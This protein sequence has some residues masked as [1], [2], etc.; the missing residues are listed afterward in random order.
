M[1]S[2][3][4]LVVIG[5]GQAGAELAVQAR[6]GGWAGGI[7][8][9][10]D[11][12]QLP[13]HRPPLSKSGLTDAS[14]AD[15][16][17][18]KARTTY[19]KAGIELM[20]GRL[21][22]HVDLALATVHFVDGTSMP[23]TRL[24]FTTG[25]RARR[26]P[27][28]D[29]L[30]QRI[31]NVHTLRS[32]ADAQRLRAGLVPGQRLVVI[33][34]GFVGLEVAAIAAAKGLHVVLLEAA[35]RL[36]SRVTGAPVADFLAQ[37][38]RDAGV[39]VRTGLSVE[40][41]QTDAAGVRVTSVRCAG[42]ERFATDCVLIGIGLEPHTTLARNAGLPVD[43]GIV[44]DG[45]CRTIMPGI[46]AAGDCTRQY[47]ALYGRPLRLESVPN[48]VD[49]ARAAAASVNGLD[50]P[51][52]GVPWF[53]SDQ[54]DLK[55]KTAGLSQDHDRLVLRGAPSSRAFTVF[56]LQGDRVLA[57]DTINRPAEFM[58]AKRLIAER[59]AVDPARLADDKQPL[60]TLFPS[61]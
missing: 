20:M 46:V 60:K 10:G 36:L 19:A 51:N 55:L 33:G 49:Q 59:V 52:T 48:A 6:E 38:H 17:A 29:A 41:L 42:G 15:A 56:Y 2:H 4:M 3:D 43:D 47:S 35:S 27:A 53:W 58:L 37:V 5:A 57:A 61:S 7:A 21:V 12:P 25:G 23:Y 8:L 13:Y 22:A 14:D 40:Q 30:D 44:V 28:Q 11:E 50:R 24:A 18:I 39:D 1:P 54:Y 34:G 26:L 31:T 9:I 16:L 32:F 45:G